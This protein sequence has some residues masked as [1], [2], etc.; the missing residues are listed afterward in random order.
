M[1]T[2]SVQKVAWGTNCWVKLHIPSIRTFSDPD[3]SCQ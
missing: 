2:T 1:A 3:K